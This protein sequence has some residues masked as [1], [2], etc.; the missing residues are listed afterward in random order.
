MRL[1]AAGII[2]YEITIGSAREAACCKHV[3][4]GLESSFRD[5]IRDAYKRKDMLARK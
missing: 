3:A 1:E 4:V 2:Q 5:S